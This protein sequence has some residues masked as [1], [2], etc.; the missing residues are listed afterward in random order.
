MSKNEKKVHVF[1]NLSTPKL[2]IG[3]LVQKN[4]KIFF[5]YDYKFLKS[6]LELSPYVLPLK[7]GVF[8]CSDSTFEGLWGL[9][10]DSIPNGLEQLIV[11]E[12]LKKENIDPL[13]I[14]PL[15]RLCYIGDFTMGALSYEFKE[16]ED[17]NWIVNDLFQIACNI[18]IEN[19]EENFIKRVTSN[20]RLSEEI[21]WKVPILYHNSEHTMH[22]ITKSAEQDYSQIFVKFISP[23]DSM[24][25]GAIECAYSLMSKDAK[26]ERP[27]D[28]LVKN[29]YF[30][31]M[32]YDYQENKRLH[33]HSVAGLIHSDI[34]N[35]S[36]DYDDLLTLTLDLTKDV[37][38]QEKVFRV[39]C[40]NLFSCNRNDHVKNFSFMMDKNGIWK[41]APSYN[42]TFSN[43]LNGEHYTKYLGEGKNPTEK[44]LM[45][46]ASKHM[47]KNSQKIIKEVKTSIS[48]WIQ[49]AKK[50]NLS[51]ETCNL[52]LTEISKRLN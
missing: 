51:D 22:P 13:D 25:S 32:R 7:E 28:F 27:N 1:L 2:K 9:F 42:I 24:E 35:P 29:K 26:L 12:Y 3:T 8:E 16:K 14:T 11:D 21:D 48:N 49:F 4:K 19:N 38:E 52:I 34:R 20:N 33:V 47:I 46:L 36:L 17:D 37:R 43:G 44:H 30:C 39:A 41:F 6:T 10:N 5:E 50:A 31:Y 23:M 15:D 45:D 40:F 18:L